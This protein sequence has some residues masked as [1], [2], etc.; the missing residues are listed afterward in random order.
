M[1]VEINDGTKV[2]ILEDVWVRHT[3]S[4]WNAR[5]VAGGP[6]VARKIFDA[7]EKG[8]SVVLHGAQAYHGVTT[9]RLVVIGNRIYTRMPRG[10]GRAPDFDA[11]GLRGLGREDSMDKVA[12]IFSDTDGYH[13]CSEELPY[14]DARGPAFRTK[15]DALRHA[16]RAGYTHAVGSGTYRDGKIPASYMD[17]E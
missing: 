15:A 4:E 3:G 7:L 14:L 8:H 2:E 1:H 17:G 10:V 13:V 12:R 9:R 6:G 16:A 11:R 5:R